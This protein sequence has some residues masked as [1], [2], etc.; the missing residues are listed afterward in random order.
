[1]KNMEGDKLKIIIVL[2]KQYPTF[3]KGNEIHISERNP[4][5]CTY[6]CMYIHVCV[7]VWNYCS[8]TDELILV[9]KGHCGRINKGIW[10]PLN[11]FIISVVEDKRD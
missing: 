6:I 10:G 9:M 2:S 11:K 3:Q 8:K 5:I 4:Y 1:M 7:C